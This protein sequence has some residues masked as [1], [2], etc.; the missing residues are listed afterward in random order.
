M[1]NRVEKY[2][3]KLLNVVDKTNNSG[4]GSDDAKIIFL[5]NGILDWPEEIDIEKGSKYK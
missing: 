2:V 1:S 3:N 5:R 4:A